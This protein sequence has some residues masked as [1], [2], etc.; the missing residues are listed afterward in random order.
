MQ[1]SRS[2]SIRNEDGSTETR[3]A[4]RRSCSVSHDGSTDNPGMTVPHPKAQ[5]LQSPCLNISDGCLLSDF[6]I[7]SFSNSAPYR[8]SETTNSFIYF[9]I[10]LFVDLLLTFLSRFGGKCYLPSSTYCTQSSWL[11]GAAVIDRRETGVLLL[12]R[13]HGLLWS[14]Y[15]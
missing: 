2:S 7:S 10:Y 15:C 1:R 8:D 5:I 4:W 13:Q 9:V 11:A 12:P 3:Q 14:L 6:S